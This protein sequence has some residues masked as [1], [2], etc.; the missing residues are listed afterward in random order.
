MLV[1]TAKKGGRQQKSKSEADCQVIAPLAQR[2]SCFKSKAGP[3]RLPTAAALR[4]SRQPH[5]WM[6]Q[7]RSCTQPLAGVAL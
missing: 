1:L 6:R 4:L 7:R 3:S 2:V 5:P